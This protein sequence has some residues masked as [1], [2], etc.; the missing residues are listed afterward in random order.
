MSTSSNSRQTILDRLRTIPIDFS[1]APPIDPSRLVQYTNP[2][3]KFSQILNHVGGAVHEIERIELVA[4]I[5]GALPSFANARYVASL[6]PE[7]VRGNFPLEQVDDPHLLAHLDWA[8]TRGQFAVAENGAIW[9]RP[10]NV[11]ERAMLFLTQHLAIVVLK[12]NFAMHMHEAYRRLQADEQFGH[13]GAGF[14]VFVSG[15]SK[16]ADIEQSLVIGAHGC[17]SLQVFLLDE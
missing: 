10:A 5:L 3:S 8:V 7:A 14:G 15:P 12:N 1:P 9:V 16:T 17:R 11:V 2:A 4:E 13:S 6:V